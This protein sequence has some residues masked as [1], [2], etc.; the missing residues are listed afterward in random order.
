MKYH[1][2]SYVSGHTTVASIWSTKHAIACNTKDTRDKS[3]LG[4]MDIELDLVQLGQWDLGNLH[5]DDDC[6]FL[7]R[8][9]LW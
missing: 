8:K 4:K 6:E 3:K 5:L 9:V 7:S 1:A 2:K